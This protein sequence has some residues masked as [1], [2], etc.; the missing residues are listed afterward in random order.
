MPQRLQLG[1]KESASLSAV[2]CQLETSS[3]MPY[4]TTIT[5]LCSWPRRLLSAF[6]PSRCT[7]PGRQRFRCQNKRRVE[8][9]S[10][11]IE[12]HTSCAPTQGTEGYEAEFGEL[13]S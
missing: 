7:L 1:S 6:S 10:L 9:A 2:S 8:I 4:A 12:A 13:W 5:R 11:C 3:P